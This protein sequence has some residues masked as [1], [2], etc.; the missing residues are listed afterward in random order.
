MAYANRAGQLSRHRNRVSELSHQRTFE[1]ES[2]LQR[3]TREQYGEHARYISGQ[4]KVSHNGRACNVG[5]SYVIYAGTK[6]DE[7]KSLVVQSMMK[8]KPMLQDIETQREAAEALAEGTRA[9]VE[10]R[11]IKAQSGD[12]THVMTL[13]NTAK[14]Q[15]RAYV[16]TI[17]SIHEARRRDKETD[18]LRLQLLMVE[19]N[20]SP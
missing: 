18:K 17:E 13:V 12:S 16:Q 1:F 15:Y 11:E 9:P 3:S 4:R 7:Y 6:P 8:E 5:F 19:D 14:I 20:M 10:V 2:Y